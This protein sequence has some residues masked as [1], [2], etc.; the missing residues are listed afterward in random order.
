MENFNQISSLL[1]LVTRKLIWYL[2]YYS[3]EQLSFLPI[4]IKDVIRVKALRRLSNLSSNKFSALLHDEV[5]SIELS[6][7]KEVNQEHV[8]ALEQTPKLV[9]L[10]LSNLIIQNCDRSY[11][12]GNEQCCFYCTSVSVQLRRSLSSLTS[13]VRLDL[14]HAKSIV[15]DEVVLTVCK[16]SRNLQQIELDT[17]SKVTDASIASLVTSSIDTNQEGILGLASL[18]VLRCL[19]LAGTSVSDDGLLK[20]STFT[21]SFSSLKELNLNKCQK[22]GDQGILKV[23]DTFDNLE[24]MSFSHCK[25]VSM[26]SVNRLS[27]YFE[28]KRTSR[29]NEGPN[30]MKQISFSIW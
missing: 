21:K 22:I 1:E 15:N 20:L 11:D 25:N 16:N 28:D 23:L 18:S 5:L 6:F 14:S 4:T 3:I 9:S 30:N 7:L 27:E 17:C 29:N 12:V 26:V 24:I 19:G 13:L 2:N 8:K 10:N